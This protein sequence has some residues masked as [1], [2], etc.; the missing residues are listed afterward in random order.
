MTTGA[1]ARHAGAALA[2]LVLCSCVS[3]RG[4]PTGDV[5]ASR[6]AVLVPPADSEFVPFYCGGAPASL[7][8]PSL[9]GTTWSALGAT[10]AGGC[11]LV[12]DGS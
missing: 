3:D 7:L 4:A 6:S 8:Q 12:L 1:L 2:L 10:S 9:A 11:R 5:L